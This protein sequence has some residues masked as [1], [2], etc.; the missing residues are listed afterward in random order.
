MPVSGRGFNSP[1]LHPPGHGN[2][3]HRTQGSLSPD[4]EPFPFPARNPRC[5]ELR[6][7]CSRDGV[8]RP[9]A[10][11]PAQKGSKAQNHV[12]GCPAVPKWP[13]DFG[14]CTYRRGSFREFARKLNPSMMPQNPVTIT[15]PFDLSIM[16]LK[17]SR[18]IKS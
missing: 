10:G 2:V 9:L 17:K 11:M 13:S 12:T 3:A 1:R 15:Y 4:G 6:G 18:T 5:C 16:Y 14:C 8:A 7:C